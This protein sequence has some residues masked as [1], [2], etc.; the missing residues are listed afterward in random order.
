MISALG[1]P[2]R[3]SKAE[4]WVRRKSWCWYQQGR[5]HGWPGDTALPCPCSS[6]PPSCC[7]GSRNTRRWRIAS[8]SSWPSCAPGRKGTVP[9]K[10]YLG[11]ELTVGGMGLSLPWHR[12]E[13]SHLP[14]C[15]QRQPGPG[16]EFYLWLRWLRAANPLS[17]CLCSEEAVP[18]NS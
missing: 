8:H 6:A 4:A 16:W 10:N 17:S 13:K 18:A 5:V 14:A 3:P 12:M 7:P 9:S 2:C 1:W 11:P 15:S